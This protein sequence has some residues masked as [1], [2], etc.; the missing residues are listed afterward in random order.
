MVVTN[1]HIPWSVRRPAKDDTALVVEPDGVQTRQVAVEALQ[2]ISGRRLQVV[3]RV[4]V[5]EHVEFSVRNPGDPASSQR[6]RAGC[7]PKKAL[8]GPT[9][10]S[11]NRHDSRRVYPMQ[12]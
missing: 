11:L 6:R 1:V 8:D 5:I 4:G 10:E 3:Q 2:S 7:H 12:V 9:G